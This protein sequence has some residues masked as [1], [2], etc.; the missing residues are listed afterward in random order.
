[1]SSMKLYRIHYDIPWY[2]CIICK[3]TRLGA[4]SAVCLFIPG[5]IKT[6]KKEYRDDPAVNLGLYKNSIGKN[7]NVFDHMPLGKV[8]E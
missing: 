3:R 6:T 4:I 5:L 7:G 8:C 2:I 1:M